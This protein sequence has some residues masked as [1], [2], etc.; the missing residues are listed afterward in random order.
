MQQA[1]QRPGN[2]GRKWF[3]CRTIG[4]GRAQFSSHPRLHP[5]SHRQFDAVFAQADGE[6]AEIT[7]SG[8]I[9]GKLVGR[10]VRRRQ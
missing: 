6:P 10:F 5:P 8:L 7:G 2:A 9:R 3:V 4:R 1:M